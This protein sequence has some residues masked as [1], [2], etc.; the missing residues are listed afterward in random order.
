[1]KPSK[2]ATKRR[3]SKAEEAGPKPSAKK[4]RRLEGA[5]AEVDERFQMR[6][7]DEDRETTVDPPETSASKKKKKKKKA[8]PKGSADAN[9]SPAPSSKRK[10]KR[11]ST[12]DLE[13]ANEDVTFSD[14]DDD[15]DDDDGDDEKNSADARL[16]DVQKAK[17]LVLAERAKRKQAK[18]GVVYLGAIP[19]RM[20]PQKLR[21]LLSPFGKLD[22]VYLTPED[23]GTRLRR[24]KFGGNTGKNFTEG[25]VEF[26]DKKK[27]RSC[28]EMLN[29]TQIGGKRRSA[30][31]SDL[32]MLKYLPKFKWD[33]LLEEIE[34]QKAIRDQKMQLE[35]AVAKKERDF[36]L[37]K[38]EQSKQIEAMVRRRVAEG[39][40]GDELNLADD[41]EE[42]KEEYDARIAKE[43]RERKADREMLLRKFKQRQAVGDVNVDDGRG[44]MAPDVLRDLFAASAEGPKKRAG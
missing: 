12:E 30:H 35:L 41:K 25:W 9:G 7:E 39:Q 22:R 3:P 32:W 44:M 19:P 15:D 4:R 21:Q 16:L 23:P 42:T 43:K 29:G 28:A 10:K 14:L 1:M 37:A 8:E 26:L 5:A 13:E 11:L 18:R 38:V 20:K 40:S 2:T 17:R 34:Y 36:Y 6:P 24:K 27:A 33:N 31:Y